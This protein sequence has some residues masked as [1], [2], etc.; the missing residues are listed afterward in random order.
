LRSLALQFLLLDLTD[1]M[2]DESIKNMPVR[3]GDGEARATSTP[4]R[5]P[6]V[7][8]T[9]SAKERL[10]LVRGELVAAYVC[11]AHDVVR[12]GASGSQDLETAVR[13]PPSCVDQAVRG[14]AHLLRARFG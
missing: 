4:V 1:G 14:R 5:N 13:E 10:Q 2:P 11:E 9:E 7:V 6:P 8:T 12:L 3:R